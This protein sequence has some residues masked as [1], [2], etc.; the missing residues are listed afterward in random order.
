MPFE[1]KLHDCRSR[2]RC[3]GTV[4]LAGWKSYE[5]NDHFEEIVLYSR[6]VC[7]QSA[8][9]KLPMAVAVTRERIWRASFLF[10]F[11]CAHMFEAVGC[12]TELNWVAQRFEG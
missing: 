12:T 3:V 1:G 8:I 9:L 7:D 6:V 5:P 10:V 11:N 4:R 2:K